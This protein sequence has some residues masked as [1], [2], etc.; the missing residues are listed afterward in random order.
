MTDSKTNSQTGAAD[1]TSITETISLGNVDDVT[2]YVDDNAG[3][4]PASYDI[5]IEAHA[6]SGNYMTHY[7]ATG[8]TAYRH[9][10]SPLGEEA[11]ITVTNASGGAADHRVR[12][13]YE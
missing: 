1:G 11:Q 3:G 6:G 9:D 5:S 10:A 4:A 12:V 2:V 8:S 13:V 7:E